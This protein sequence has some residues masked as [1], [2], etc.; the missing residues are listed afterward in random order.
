MTNPIVTEIEAVL[1]KFKSPQ[2]AIQT[3]A[4]LVASFGA[5]GIL[6]APLTGWLQ[7]VLTAVLAL[8]VAVTGKSATTAVLRRQAKLVELK[9]DA[10]GVYRA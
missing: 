4:A 5:V 2:I 7:G 9:P 8:I 3:L 1:A 10:D 6:N